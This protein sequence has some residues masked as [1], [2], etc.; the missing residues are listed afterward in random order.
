MYIVN[1]TNDQTAVLPDLGLEIAPGEIVTIS[2][3][4]LVGSKDLTAIL[5]K[6]AIKA[7]FAAGEAA[8]NPLFTTQIRES[9]ALGCIERLKLN[10]PKRVSRCPIPIDEAEMALKDLRSRT[11]KPSKPS[12]LERVVVQGQLKQYLLQAVFVAI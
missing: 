9:L 6:G 3:E 1:I 4:Q 7:L 10:I 12:V 2:L 8:N 5:S 11:P